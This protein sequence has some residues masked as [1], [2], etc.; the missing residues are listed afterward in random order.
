MIERTDGD[1]RAVGIGDGDAVADTEEVAVGAR[2]DVGGGIHHAELAIDAE[3]RAGDLER[4]AKP[5][6]LGPVVLGLVLDREFEIN[7]GLVL[8]EA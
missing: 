5:V 8:G 6:G 1:A 7:V 3:L 2:Q 4:Q